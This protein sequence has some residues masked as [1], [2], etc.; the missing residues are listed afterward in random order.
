MV[1]TGKGLEGKMEEYSSKQARAVTVEDFY[2]CGGNG[3]S[4][5]GGAVLYMFIYIVLKCKK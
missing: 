1:N 3:L 2:H 5:A 4:T